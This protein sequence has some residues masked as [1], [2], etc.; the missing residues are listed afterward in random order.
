M[1]GLLIG[2]KTSDPSPSSSINNG[3][4]TTTSSNNTLSTNSITS[5]SNIITNICNVPITPI[6]GFSK[7]SIT[8]PTKF[9]YYVDGVKKTYSYT[10]VTT[11][12]YNSTNCNLAQVAVTSSYQSLNNSIIEYTNLNFSAGQFKWDDTLSM[13][14]SNILN[15][16]FS[17]NSASLTISDSLQVYYKLK[18]DPIGINNNLSI[19]QMYYIPWESYSYTP[20]FKKFVVLASLKFRVQNAYD[21]TQ[22]KT[23][24]VDTLIFNISTSI[25]L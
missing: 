18:K 11:N 7:S 2:C 13:N 15:K 17:V 3:S 14:N 8:L 23:I 25:N 6:I 4:T 19:F 9:T 24:Q 20:A 16:Y 5:I 22:I 21:T 12:Q 1:T 10:G